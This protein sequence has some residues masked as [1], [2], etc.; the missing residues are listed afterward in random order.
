MSFARFIF[1]PAALAAI[2]FTAGCDNTL[3]LP[4]AAIPNDIDTLTLYA[5]QGTA[6][7]DPSGFDVV[8]GL[9][10]RTDRQSEQFDIA[11]DIDETGRALIFPTTALGLPGESGIQSSNK[12]F[13]DITLAPLEDYEVEDP[14]EV[15]VESVFIV[16]SRPDAGLGAAACAFF[17]GRLPR[18]GKFRVL[19]IDSVE[20]NIVMEI[21][22]NANCGYR[23]LEVGVPIQ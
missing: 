2:A 4:P 21:L 7:S 17:L 11:F 22:I 15:G 18:Y 9:T 12:Q 3:T 13:A 10:S 16:R 20:R 1:A 6:I 8:L 14:L 5:L 19:S 23:G